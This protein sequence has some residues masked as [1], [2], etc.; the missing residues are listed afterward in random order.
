[1]PAGAN[2]GAGFLSDTQI[3]IHCSDSQ[4]ES[5]HDVRMR[6]GEVVGFAGVGLQ[7]KQGWEGVGR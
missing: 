1:M 6:P 5:C 2:P 7:I 3:L 4:L